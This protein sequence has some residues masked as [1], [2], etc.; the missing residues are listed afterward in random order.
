MLCSRHSSS[1]MC[2]KAENI[3]KIP[4]G[5]P[6]SLLNYSCSPRGCCVI[7]L[8]ARFRRV[9]DAARCSAADQRIPAMSAYAIFDVD[10]RDMTLG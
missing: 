7:R 10:I 1:G 6:L 9:G 2:G 3:S 5:T 8:Q 4:A